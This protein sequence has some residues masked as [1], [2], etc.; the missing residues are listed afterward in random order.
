MAPRTKFCLHLLLTALTW[1]VAWLAAR[2]FQV[3][4]GRVPGSP[5]SRRRVGVLA[6]NPN[7]G[8]IADPG[9][10]LES[11]KK[12]ARSCRYRFALCLTEVP[13]AI[14]AL[15]QRQFQGKIAIAVAPKSSVQGSSE[16]AE[17]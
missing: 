15:E 8:L 14:T 5:D 17:R 4:S 2:F 9:D 16:P 11:K 6:S 12:R 1:L 13:E 3:S 10:L 7:P